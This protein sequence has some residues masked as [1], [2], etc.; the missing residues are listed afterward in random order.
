MRGRT[1][2]DDGWTVR[3]IESSVSIPAQLSHPIAA[4]VPGCVH[5]DLI[6]ANII[7]HPDLKDGEYSQKWVGH[8]HFRWSRVITAEE[9]SAQSG[10]GRYLNLVFNSID[11]VGIIRMKLISNS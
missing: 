11:T 1:Y 10:E 9:M 6:A 3:A 2:L 4:K 7:Q 8:T 5:K